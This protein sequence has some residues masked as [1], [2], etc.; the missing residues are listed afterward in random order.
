MIR[1]VRLLTAWLVA[2]AA[3]APSTLLAQQADLTTALPV[4][5]TVRIGQFDNGLRYY[6]RVNQRPEQRAEL[7]VNLEA[8]R[9][10]RIHIEGAGRDLEFAPFV[11]T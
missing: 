5:T 10:W 4:D 9:T 7:L 3:F 6:I 2:V 1:P 8:R 11:Q